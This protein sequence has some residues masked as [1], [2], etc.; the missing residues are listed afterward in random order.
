M[1]RWIGWISS[2]LAVAVIVHVATLHVLSRRID[3]RIE[4][5]VFA[6]IGRLNA[7]HF[8]RRPDENSRG[9][10]RPSPDL[11]YAS[12]PF[13]LSKGPLRLIAHVAHTTYWSVAGFDAATNNFFVRDDRQVTGDVIDLIVVRPGM[14]P[15]PSSPGE[16]IVHA[17][18]DKGLFLTRILINDE[19]DLPGLDAIR[20]QASCETVALMLGHETSGL[21]PPMQAE[22]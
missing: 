15:P 16:T 3:R 7:M 11:L 17:P 19:R 14:T 9:V 6:N 21:P 13:D 8:G 2:V 5:R 12:C 18:T 20:H 10:V 1:S 4:S 22:H